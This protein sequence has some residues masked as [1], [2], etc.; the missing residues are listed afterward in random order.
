[1]INLVVSTSSPSDTCFHSTLLLWFYLSSSLTRV[2]SDSLHP[3]PCAPQLPPV[4]LDTVSVWSA[5]NGREHQA[6]RSRSVAGGPRDGGQPPSCLESNSC[7]CFFSFLTPYA[8]STL[9]SHVLGPA[10]TISHSSSLFAGAHPLP[11]LTRLRTQRPPLHLSMTLVHSL[12]RR[13]FP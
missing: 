12:L 7:S 10:D 8:T 5:D 4:P 11:P 2:I 9:H 1:M 6:C 3:P 13:F